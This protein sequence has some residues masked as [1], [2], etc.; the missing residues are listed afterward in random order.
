MSADI[1]EAFKALRSTLL[2][3][4][5]FAGMLGGGD[6][7]FFS[8]PQVAVANLPLIDLVLAGLNPQGNVSKTGLWRPTFDIKTVGEDLFK[9]HQVIGYLEETWSIPRER[10]EP[11]DSDHFS[12]TEISFG[13]TVQL[14]SRT[15]TSSNTKVHLLNTE[16]SLRVVRR[17]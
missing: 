2:G 14:G 1:S 16:L 9:L 7:I 11:I 12:I 10:R 8:A 15:L 6:S 17:S 3:D 5:T 4:A 13:Q